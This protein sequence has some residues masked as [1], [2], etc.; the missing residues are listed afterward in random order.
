MIL[1]DDNLTSFIAAVEEGHTIYANM[2]QFIRYLI[3]S[4]I[5]EVVG[6][7]L[8]AAFSLPEALISNQP[9][10]VN[11][12]INGLPVT[13]LSFNPPDIAIMGKPLCGAKETLITP[14]LFFRYMAVSVYLGATVGA[15]SYWFLFDPTG[16]LT[17]N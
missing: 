3:I 13:A 9:L 6:I 2:K 4:K 17:N 7:F 1:A 11:P 15:S 8:A 12:V 10:W 5:G 14:W 16:G